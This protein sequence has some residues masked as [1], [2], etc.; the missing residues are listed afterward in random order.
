MWNWCLGNIAILCHS[1]GRCLGVE[2][3]E[4]QRQAI[5]S[6]CW[7]VVSSLTY[8]FLAQTL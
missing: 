3:V 2:Q 4:G 1:R 6:G 5:L 7:L 8:W